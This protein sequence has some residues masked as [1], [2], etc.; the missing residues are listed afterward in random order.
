MLF[1]ILFTKTAD[2]PEMALKIEEMGYLEIIGR[3]FTAEVGYIGLALI[4]LVEF[5]VRSILDVL[6]RALRCCVPENEC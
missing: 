6:M 4:A 3:R 1:L 5:V 2:Q